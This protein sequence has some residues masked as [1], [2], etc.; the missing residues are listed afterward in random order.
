MPAV[1][2]PV[3]SGLVASFAA[4]GGNA[5]GSALLSPE[6]APKW[7][8]LLKDVLPGLIDVAILVPVPPDVAS[9]VTQWIQ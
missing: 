9:Q 6:V 2:D 1:N 5:T 7:L 4:P 8:E 3:G